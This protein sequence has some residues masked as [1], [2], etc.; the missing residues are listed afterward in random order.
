ME[1]KQE[2]RNWRVLTLYAMRV[3]AALLVV[4]LE[5]EVTGSL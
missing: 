4:I 5:A 1:S 2:E 3:G